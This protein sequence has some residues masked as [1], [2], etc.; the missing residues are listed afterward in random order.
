MTKL[1]VDARRLA[2]TLMRED[3]RVVFA[4]SCTAG[5]VAASL[6]KVPGISDFLCG[7]AVTYRN[8]TKHQWLGVSEQKLNRPG[9]VSAIVASQMAEGVLAMTPEADWSAAI[10]GH[11]GPSAP[12]RLDGVV[13]VGIARRM[14]EL[15]FEVKT[16]R[17]VLE[18]DA[19]IARQREAAALVLRI[20]GDALECGDLS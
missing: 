13:Y 1:P 17:F 12:K 11:L 15:P 10:T 4:E 8:D 2:K 9:P 7:S 14:K 5:L 6:A 19:R 3:L 18:S 20:L 16:H